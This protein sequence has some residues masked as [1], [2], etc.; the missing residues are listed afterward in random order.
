MKGA[1]NITKQASFLLLSPQYV[2]ID[3]SVFSICLLT[4]DDNPN[5]QCLCSHWCKTLEEQLKIQTDKACSSVN[6]NAL[7]LI[8]FHFDA[9]H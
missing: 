7:I 9:Y 1:L 4:K 3:F 5:M 6:F 2:Y 8:I